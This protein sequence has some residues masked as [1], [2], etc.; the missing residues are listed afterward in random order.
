[1]L[2][3]CCRQGNGPKSGIVFTAS[4]LPDVVHCRYCDLRAG[5]ADVVGMEIETAVAA[6]RA[7]PVRYF[8]ADYFC[9]Y[10]SCAT[11]SCGWISGLATGNGT[12]KFYSGTR[13]YRIGWNICSDEYMS[14]YKASREN[15][16]FLMPPFYQVYQ[17][18][19]QRRR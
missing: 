11:Q 1:M 2:D 13:W 17:F 3:Y 12:D 4:N 15:H 10:P 8:A 14:R 9:Y 7:C 18:Y 6:V 5:S 19:A 16:R